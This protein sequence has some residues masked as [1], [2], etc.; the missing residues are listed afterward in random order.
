MSVQVD[1]Y[2]YYTYTFMINAVKY[3]PKNFS[4]GMTYNL[5]DS[6]K[7]VI[8]TDLGAITVEQEPVAVGTVTIT[9]TITDL[10]NIVPVVEN[11]QVNI[12]A[13]PPVGI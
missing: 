10:T 2:Q 11:A 5:N 6:S 9:G 8:Q 1:C 12:N 7:N 3:L 13:V 4:Y